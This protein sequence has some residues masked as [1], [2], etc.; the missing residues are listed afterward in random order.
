MSKKLMKIAWAIGTVLN[1]GFAALNFSLGITGWA[2]FNVC[3]SGICHFN[4][5]SVNNNE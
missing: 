1:L 3:I 4:Y 5:L 2:I